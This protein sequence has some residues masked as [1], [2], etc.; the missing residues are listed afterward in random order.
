MKKLLLLAALALPAADWVSNFRVD[1]KALSA[2]GNNPYFILTP[3]FRLHYEHGRETV[4]T[5]VLN[6]TKMIDGVETRVVED[7]ETKNG[8][9]V[10]LTRDYFA[11]DRYTGDVYYFGED[12]DTYRNGKIVA[13]E[14]AWRSGSSGARFGLMMPGSPKVGQRFYQ[15][16]APGVA[17]DRA[18]IVAVGETVRTPA[19]IFANCVKVKETNPLEKSRAEYKWYAPGTGMVKEGDVVLVSRD[20]PK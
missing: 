17:M 20:S 7:R 5:T 3:G 11:V 18:E 8:Q 4:T 2:T 1:R 10:E 13:H 16:Q 6:E 19:G 14:G 9:L 12:V 15:E